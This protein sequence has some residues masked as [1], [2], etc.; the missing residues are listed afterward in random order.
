MRGLQPRW[1][2]GGHWR[3][4]TCQRFPSLCVCNAV[5]ASGAASAREAGG[6]GSAPGCACILSGSPCS[7]R[8]HGGRALAA[9]RAIRGGVRGAL[10]RAPSVGACRAPHRGR[11]RFARA[12]QL[13]NGRAIRRTSLQTNNPRTLCNAG[14]SCY[15][16][17]RG[18]P[19]AEISSSTR[20]KPVQSYR[21]VATPPYSAGSNSTR[22]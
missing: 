20:S 3:R 17:H 13:R 16:R 14:N 10:A 9:W 1:Q 18:I 19:R 12:G 22:S 7:E 6:P 5:S 15:R 21:V 8:R 2:D 11:Q 4:A